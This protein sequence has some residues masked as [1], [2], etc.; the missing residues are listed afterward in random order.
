MSK[1]TTHVVP[2]KDGGWNIKGGGSKRSSGHFDRKSDAVDRAREISQNKGSELYIHNK[3]GK[4][5]SKD[6]HGNDSYP[7]KG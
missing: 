2:S 3:D 4:I 7:P 6:S 5:G 1:K